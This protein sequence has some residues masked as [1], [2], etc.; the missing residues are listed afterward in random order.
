[1][2]R[3]EDER[4]EQARQARLPRRHKG[5]ARVR[6]ALA[7]PRDAAGR[8][9]LTHAPGA[10][11]RVVTSPA[12]GRLCRERE[13]PEEE[14]KEA[15][16]DARQERRRR[17]VVRA[18]DRGQQQA[19]SS[20]V[21]RCCA[22]FASASHECSADAGL[23]ARRLSMHCRGSADAKFKG[24]TLFLKKE[25]KG[26]DSGGRPVADFAGG[27]GGKKRKGAGGGGKKK[28]GGGKKKGRR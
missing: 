26:G 16:G 5:D 18:C 28:G 15:G 1:M 10:T 24:G 6:L 3:K 25:T 13:A 22:L 27:F 11:T 4:E 9:G 19:T 12:A 14:E 21:H 8:E 2:A 17:G 20:F 7:S 23:V